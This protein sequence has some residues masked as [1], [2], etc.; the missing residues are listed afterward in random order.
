MKF[1]FTA[2]VTES[3]IYLVS[4]S[5]NITRCDTFVELANVCRFLQWDKTDRPLELI[6]V[7]HRFYCNQCDSELDVDE[8]T[9]STYCGNCSCENLI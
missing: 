5:S 7:T 1:H 6:D 4:N 2:I 9:D 3:G 8:N